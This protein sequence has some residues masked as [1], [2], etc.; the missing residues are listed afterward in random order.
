MGTINIKP[1]TI[2]VTSE[3][4]KKDM[5]IYRHSQLKKFN[6]QVLGLG[7][8]SADAQEREVIAA[9]FDLAGFTK[10]CAQFD[11]YLVVPK[12]LSMFLNWLFGQVTDEM[13]KKKYRQGYSFHNHLPFFAK[14]LGDGVLFLW[15]SRKMNET[16]RCNTIVGLNNICNRYIR[17]F[18]PMI[19]KEV[20]SVPSKLRCGV[21]RG[22]VLSL[23]NGEDYVGP[24]I[25]IAA[26][27]QKESRVT[28]CFQRKGFEY[29]KG[30]TEETASFYTVRAITIRGIENKELVCVRKRDFDGLSKRDKAV[31]SDI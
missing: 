11:P 21:A 26:R 14:F 16:L 3:G 7:N 6:P 5:M 23:G 30:M 8:L 2:K 12:F 17:S 1:Q 4:T 13:M 20:S 31:F 24:C 29:E 28:F 9:V 15:D 10:L 25:N 19:R 18:V 22:K 27:L